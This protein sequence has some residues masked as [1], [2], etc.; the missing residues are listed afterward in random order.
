MKLDITMV[1]S[2]AAIAVAAP[3]ALAEDSFAPYSEDYTRGEPLPR[4]KLK[5]I[6]HAKPLLAPQASPRR[7][8]DAGRRAPRKRAEGTA[9]IPAP[10]VQV[11]P[12][13]KSGL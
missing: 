10:S 12:L 7:A 3:L 9:G 13:P 4:E 11:A 5:T 2:A 8:A 1:V 6:E